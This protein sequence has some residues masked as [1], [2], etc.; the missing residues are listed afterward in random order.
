MPKM[1]GSLR[2]YPLRRILS[3]K[4]GSGSRID[5]TK[6]WKEMIRQGTDIPYDIMGSPISHDEEIRRL[7]AAQRVKRAEELEQLKKPAKPW[8]AVPRPPPGP[9]GTYGA[10]DLTGTRWKE[11]KAGE[12][13]LPYP[14]VPRRYDENSAIAGMDPYMLW[15]QRANV[16]S[17]QD[18]YMEDWANQDDSIDDINL[19][20]L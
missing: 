8:S 10:P 9:N 1:Y 12:G 16:T 17:D 2:E 20:N 7:E 19:A 11:L 4:G 13:G 5:L 15:L 6:S 3:L 18:M 14:R